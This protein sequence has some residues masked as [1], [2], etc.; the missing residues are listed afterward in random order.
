[1]SRR[2]GAN[3]GVALFCAVYVFVLY[4]SYA[5]TFGLRD[6]HVM[7]P[8]NVCYKIFGAML[9]ELFLIMDGVMLSM[10]VWHY[11]VVREITKLQFEY[12]QDGVNEN[13]PHDG[14]FT[15]VLLGKVRPQ[16][17]TRYMVS[18]NMEM[19]AAISWSQGKNTVMVA[20]RSL[21]RTDVLEVLLYSVLGT[22]LY[23]YYYVVYLHLRRAPPHEYKT[24]IDCVYRVNVILMV[25]SLIARISML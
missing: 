14:T 12:D 23:C 18:H 10:F 13:A 22:V 11:F 2:V 19:G 24:M 4:R 5:G 21:L 20:F 7:S 16:D 1:M 25:G 8:G 15:Q 3:M 6:L 9:T 17:F